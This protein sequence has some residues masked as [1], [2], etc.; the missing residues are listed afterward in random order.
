M[1]KIG[2]IFLLMLL[3]IIFSGCGKNNTNINNSQNQ[4]LNKVAAINENDNINSN[5][6]TE[7]DTS[8][9]QIFSNQDMGF[10]FEYP[11]LS[12]NVKF[13]YIKCSGQEKC[14]GSI[15]GKSYQWTFDEDENKFY[16][17]AGSSTIGY[18]AGRSMEL[19]DAVRY[20]NNNNEYSIITSA[21]YSY[22]VDPVNN[23][24]TNL[25]EAIIYEIKDFPAYPELPEQYHHD[26]IA[27][28][29]FN[30]AINNFESVSFYIYST[31]SD[32]DIHRIINSITINISEENIVWNTYRY[33]KYGFSFE[34]PSTWN[35]SLVNE[36]GLGTHPGDIIL[37]NNKDCNIQ[38][39]VP[40]EQDTQDNIEKNLKE[41]QKALTDNVYFDKKITVI[42]TNGIDILKANGEVNA[43]SETGDIYEI[44]I[45]DKL[46]SYLLNYGVENDYCVDVSEKI[47]NSLKEQ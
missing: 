42:N 30:K 44:K 33:E 47:L 45:K 18:L 36:G 14:D 21:E 41:F 39:T 24:Q 32:E 15:T 38:L 34:Y 2:F 3:S 13:D 6:N 25:G 4:N 46:F 43:Y 27:I 29:N 40:H 26:K 16:F 35:F 31:M 28:F 23:I 1:K 12:P 9:W 7:I 19:R 17:I 8:D 10:S 22:K 5:A 11:L 37:K 20:E